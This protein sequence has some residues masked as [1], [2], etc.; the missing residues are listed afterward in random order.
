[1]AYERFGIVSLEEVFAAVRQSQARKE[2]PNAL[3]A[4]Q[5]VHTDSARLIA[6][7]RAYVE[8]GEV[9][10]VRCGLTA[11]FF[12]V[13]RHIEGR[14]EAVQKQPHLNLYSGDEVLFT[15]DHIVPKTDGG[16]K[17]PNNL[18]VMCYDCNQRKSHMDDALDKALPPKLSAEEMREILVNCPK[19]VKLG[20]SKLPD[21]IIATL[22]LEFKG[23]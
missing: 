1:M 8:N 22:F 21:R 14:S 20:L 12:A 19:A 16:T 11:S 7:K 10:C 13:E 23:K 15:V 6:F 2:R 5:V 17:S 18:Q 9:K 3:F 4:G